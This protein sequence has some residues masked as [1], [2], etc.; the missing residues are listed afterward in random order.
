MAPHLVGCLLASALASAAAF[1]PGCGA[2][3]ARSAARGRRVR[4]DAAPDGD[5]DE[6]T[7][8]ERLALRW[9]IAQLRSEIETCESEADALSERIGRPRTRPWYERSLGSFVSNNE[10][11]Q[12]A[13]QAKFE[14]LISEFQ[15][16]ETAWSAAQFLAAEAGASASS[17]A[18]A[19]AGTFLKV[20]SNLTEADGAPGA[21]RLRLASVSPSVFARAQE[22]EP[23]VPGLLA[24]LEE[25][26]PVLEPHLGEINSRLDG[27][28]PHLPYLIGA[29][30]TIVPHVATLL[31]H[32]DVL[33][34][35]AEEHT[36]YWP[37][38]ID[39]LAYVAPRLDAIAPHLPLLRPHMRTLLSRPKSV[40]VLL[41]SIDTFVPHVAISANA[42]VL[43]HYLGW[44][45]AAP[46]LRRALLLPGVPQVVALLSRVLPKS[47]VRGS[48]ST[49][50]DD[51][52]GKWDECETSYE[53]NALRYYGAPG[54]DDEVQASVTSALGPAAARRLMVRAR[55]EGFYGL[56]RSIA[57]QGRA[58]GYRDKLVSPETAS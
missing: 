36:G 33:L 27:I 35:C 8:Q 46:L 21:G 55:D 15:K 54:D 42:D 18:G 52:C 26:L 20:F 45:L 12:R 43:L 58:R 13:E 53:T 56:A 4:L 44:A 10:R 32:T 30:D 2:L 5:A 17:T 48:R 29:S 22:L 49:R 57:E 23:Q 39:C 3:H 38:D 7:I 9:R 37:A 11:S 19:V 40:P 24:F 14:R 47:P 51:P 25:Y 1:A 34:A 41:R 16:Q 6:L 28:E 50:L 31:R